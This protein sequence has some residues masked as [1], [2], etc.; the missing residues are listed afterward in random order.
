MLL[1]LESLQIQFNFDSSFHSNP[2]ENQFRSNQVDIK[3]ESVQMLK[4]LG[5]CSAILNARG[6][7]SMFGL[8]LI[9]WMIVLG[10][11]IDT[12]LTLHLFLVLSSTTFR[13]WTYQ[14]K[15]VVLAQD[16]PLQK[17]LCCLQLAVGWSLQSQ[18][19][20]RFIF[21]F[22]SFLFFCFPSFK[23]LNPLS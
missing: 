4:H 16:L 20:S 15:T 23:R 11:F 17:E 8:S 19:I 6:P 1:K 14:A 21:N 9:E 18:V 22:I 13:C 10:G 5:I 12:M 3:L 7:R 2:V